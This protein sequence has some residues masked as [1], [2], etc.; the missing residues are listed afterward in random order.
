MS[1]SLLALRPSIHK[2]HGFS[3]P[4]DLSFTK[5]NPLSVVLIDEL[6]SLLPTYALGFAKAN[7]D[8]FVLV[9]LQSI[10]K[11]ENV[12]LNED[13]HWIGNYMPNVYKGYPFVL[14]ENMK[15]EKRVNTLCF[16][17]QSDLYKEVPNEEA[18][19]LRFFDDEGNPQE[20]V[21][22]VLTSLLEHNKYRQVTIKAVEAIVKADIL[23]PWILSSEDSDKELV[24]G[25]YRINEQKLKALSGEVLET[26]NKVNALSI[27]YAQMLSIP[28]IEVLKKL[29]ELKKNKQQ[30]QEEKELNLDEFFGEGGNDTISFDF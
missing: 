27:V 15:D 5:G 1:N 19:D 23:D 24:Q 9:S 25:L 2:T 17:M 21:Q 3:L 18:G 26:L 20:I 6:T 10:Y 7:K 30:E 16:N 11:D 29:H 14:A 8:T 22:K 12:F 28:R 4:K 13:S